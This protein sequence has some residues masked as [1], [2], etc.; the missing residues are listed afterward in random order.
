MKRVLNPAMLVAVIALVLAAGGTAVA[1]GELITRPDQ[2]ATGVIEGRHLAQHSVAK[3]DL[4]DVYLRMRV[5]AAGQALGTGNDGTAVKETRG[6]YRLTFF[7]DAVDGSGPRGVLDL[8]DCA[9]TATPYATSTD[10]VPLEPNETPGAPIVW[11]AREFYGN[12]LQPNEVRVFVDK[13]WQVSNGQLV[14]L[15]KDAA[16]NV[17]VVC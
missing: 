14:Y 3:R 16:F 4:E 7:S 8:R 15:R 13:P 2:V 12:P 6:R 1:A 17:V 11:A 10:D 5:S 9:I